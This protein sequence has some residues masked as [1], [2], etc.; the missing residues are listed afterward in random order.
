MRLL[1]P[2]HVVLDD[3]Q[4]VRPCKI[5]AVARVD[6]DTRIFGVIRPIAP[7]QSPGLHNG[8]NVFQVIIG[9]VL[10]RVRVGGKL[11]NI[12]RHVVSGLE[13]QGVAQ[14]ISEC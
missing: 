1:G 12:H 11:T 7:M 10:D 3:V 2:S 8:E 14:S 9:T 5:G 4:A 13:S 6:S